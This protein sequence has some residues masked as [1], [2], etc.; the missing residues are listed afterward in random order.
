MRYLILVMSSVMSIILTSVFTYVQGNLTYKA[1]VPFDYSAPAI[2]L[3][4]Y[5][6]QLI[7]MSTSGI[8]NVAFESLFCGFLLHIC[9]QLQILAYRLTKISNSRDILNDCVRHHNL[10][11]KLVRRTKEENFDI[12]PSVFPI[13]LIKYR[14]KD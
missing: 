8:V 7:G 5:I 3:L 2:F 6:Q 12:I 9:C 10:I 4:V 14:S 13:L 1:W 11:F